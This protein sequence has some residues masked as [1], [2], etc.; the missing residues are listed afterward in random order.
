MNL[1]NLKATIGVDNSKFNKGVQSSESAFSRFGGKVTGIIAGLGIAKLGTD[2]MKLG[3]QTNASLEQSGV[4]WTTLLGTQEKSKKM[5]D[6]ITKFAASTPFSKM[7]V[8]EMAKQLNNADFKGQALFDQ[9]RKFGDMGSAFGI[10]EDSLKEMV[11]QYSQ[12]QQAGVAYTED[13]NILQ[14]RGI[15]IYK[16]LAEVTGT[17]VAE[18]KKMASEGKISADIYNKAIDGIAKNTSG[19]M[20]AQSK[21]FNGM[22]STVKD[23]FEMIIGKVMKP[24]FELAKGGLGIVADALDYVNTKLEES[25]S[26][27][28]AFGSMI[29]DIFGGAEGTVN[30]FGYAINNIKRAIERLVDIIESNAMPIFQSL[31]DFFVSF[32]EL[33]KPVIDSVIFFGQAAIVVVIDALGTLTEILGDAIDMLS[34]IG[35][36][37]Y[38]AV[39]P[40]FEEL[41]YYVDE[42]IGGIA[43]LVTDTILPAISDLVKTVK[44]G[45]DKYI[46]PVIQ[47]A[48]DF[49]ANKV[50]PLMTDAFKFLSET[51]V[52]K[53]KEV[54]E[55]VWPKIQETVSNVIQ[56]LQPIL[57]AFMTTIENIW[58]VVEFLWGVV[59]RAF[60]GI[61]DVVGWAIEKVVDIIKGFSEFLKFIFVDLPEFFSQLW[62]DIG[63]FFI[64]GWNAIASF[65]TETIPSWIENIKNWFMGL[66]EWFGQL[67]EDVKTWFTTKWTEIWT[68]LSTN[69]PLWIQSV[70]DWFQELPYK[71]GYAIGQ[72]LGTIIEWGSNVWNYLSTNVPIWIE[73]V[74]TW[75][76][77]LPGRIWNWL[78][79]VFNNVVQWGSD[80]ISKGTQ[81]ATDFVNKVV[82]FISELPGKI[83]TWLTDIISK[84]GNWGSQIVSKGSKSASD[85]VAR[86]VQFISE[87]PGRIWN[88]LTQAASKVVNWGSDLVSKGAKAAGDLT[89]AI[90]D[91]VKGIPGEMVNIGKN[92][93]EGLWNGIGNMVGWIGEKIRGFGKGVLDGLKDFFNIHSPS[94]VKRLPRISVMI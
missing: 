80:M 19:A 93:V 26:V 71:I 35:T 23:N 59:K 60:S 50:V 12:V 38:D 90:I 68:Y 77:E 61:L 17:N 88:W 43:D 62:T 14:D 79:E 52:P 58:P 91:G 76:S 48:G 1:F 3:I 15:P 16:A 85:F 28:E 4:A 72:A 9:L 31:K 82:Q 7:G 10:Q 57:E 40:A 44:D 11:R 41:F 66:P 47:R 81:I 84:V 70:V 36:T 2:M 89:K 6:D 87:L 63:D 83:W 39:A 46:L 32:G 24:F 65:F 92:I 21:T 37:I 51:V 64:N 86:V 78:T 29:S 74:V 34:D 5:L 45:F 69:I 53:V 67:W 75:F 54:F 25:N 22:M 33:I 18:V 49:I 8:D 42:Y 73:N 27:W 20:E 56:V 94:R 30:P 55:N 13:L